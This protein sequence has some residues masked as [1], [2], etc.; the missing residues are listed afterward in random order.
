MFGAPPPAI[1][2]L[3]L[4]QAYRAARAMYANIAMR[5]D[6]EVMCF[7]G[8][9]MCGSTSMATGA[10]VRV[11]GRHSRCDVVLGSEHARE[12][13]RQALALCSRDPST[14]RALF[15][16]IDLR[17]APSIELGDGRMRSSLLASGPFAC[18]IGGHVLVALPNEPLPE[19]LPEL[20]IDDHPMLPPARPQP[21][22]EQLRPVAL[23]S[24]P[25]PGRH[26]YRDAFRR[27]YISSF[28]Y[29][30]HVDEVAGVMD[31][32]GPYVL[33][34][35]AGAAMASCPVSEATL[36]RGL[37]VGRSPNCSATFLR[38]LRESTSRLHLL[39]TRDGADNVAVD[40]ASTNGMFVNGVRV[41]YV[42]LA[43]EGTT[44]RLSDGVTLT[45]RKR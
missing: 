19:G 33:E 6:Y 3:T 30:Q 4:A 45:W 27:S 44:L 37:F 22:R 17:A 42:K 41:R 14:G 28:P 20:V 43:D 12:S 15:R 40:V 5:L 35:A 25:A 10:S 2:S 18:R 39:V 32:G 24:M 38:V 9:S 13:L 31:E 16:L 7:D 34:A 26:A 36:V 23:T 8:Q 29:S 11:F 21:V 1:S